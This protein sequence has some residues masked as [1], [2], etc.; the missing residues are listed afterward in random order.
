M[1]CPLVEV[2]PG[3]F[4]KLDEMQGIQQTRMS[5]EQGKKMLFKQ[6]Y[7]SGLEGWSDKN[8]D[9]CIHALLAKYHDILS[10]EPR[11]FGCTDLAKHEIRVIDDEPFKERF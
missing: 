1:W 11:E 2:V 9:S 7:L 10:L 5:V 8:Q 4:D 6:L 3:I